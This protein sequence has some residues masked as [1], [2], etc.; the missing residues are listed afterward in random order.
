V[1]SGMKHR[2]FQVTIDTTVRSKIE[3][4]ADC[5]EVAEE[6]AL[7]EINYFEENELRTSTV[8]QVIRAVEEVTAYR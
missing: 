6:M 3:V 8:K 5:A 1:E 4:E 2:T 7:N